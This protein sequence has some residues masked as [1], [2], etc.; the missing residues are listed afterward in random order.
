MK[1]VKKD[2]FLLDLMKGD[3]NIYGQKENNIN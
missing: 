1:V 2:K 3:K